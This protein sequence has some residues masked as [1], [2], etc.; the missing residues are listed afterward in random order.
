MTPYSFGE[1]LLVP[2]PFTS[3]R[4]T[5]IAV[6]TLISL[7]HQGVDDDELLHNFPGLTPFDL[8]AA[9]AYYASQPEEI[10][11]AIADIHDAE[12]PSEGESTPQILT[13]KQNS[14]L[15]SF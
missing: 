13:L 7:Q 15:S 14:T 9:R 4:S 6:W 10:N 3:I 2:F 5:R 11:S 12:V 1:V 8:S